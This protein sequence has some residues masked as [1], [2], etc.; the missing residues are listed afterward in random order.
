LS[1]NGHSLQVVHNFSNRV[2]SVFETELLSKGLNFCFFPKL[3]LN[4]TRAEFERVYF[5]LK[6]FF[7]TGDLPVLYQKLMSLHGR[8]VSTFFHERKSH[9]CAMSEN[10]SNALH[11]LRK[12][13]NIVISKPD[14]GNGVVVLNSADYVAKMQTILRDTNKFQPC[15]NDN[16]V[17]NLLKLPFQNCLRHLKGEEAINEDTYRQIYPTAAYTPTMYGLPKIHKPDM[18]LRQILSSIGSFS[19][20]CAKWLSGSLLELRHH[21]TCVKDTLTFLSLL[22]DKSSSVKVMTSFDVTSLF[23]NVPVDFTINLILDSVFRRSDELNGLNRRRLKKLLELVVKTTTFQFNG[24]FYRQVNGV[25][26]AHL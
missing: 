16:N 26:M 11:V 17:T 4:N 12:D 1:I 25:A 22:Q 8:Y 10:E 23:T 24:R 3:H 14:K 18:P 6:R 5:E 15:D 19:Y 9:T 20:D 2:L 7:V 21:E 13:S